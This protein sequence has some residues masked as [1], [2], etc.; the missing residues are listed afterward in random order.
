MK[1][2]FILNILFIL[3]G[4][5]G[6][7]EGYMMISSVPQISYQTEAKL[8]R[9]M[10]ILTQNQ[11]L[12]I[13]ESIRF[14]KIQNHKLLINQD[15]LTFDKGTIQGSTY[16]LPQDEAYWQKHLIGAINNSKGSDFSSVSSKIKELFKTEWENL[17]KQ[18]SWNSLSDVQKCCHVLVNTLEINQNELFF[19]N[20]N[21]LNRLSKSIIKIIDK[22]Q[23]ELVSQKQADTQSQFGWQDWLTPIGLI[24]VSI[25]GLIFTNQRQKTVIEKEAQSSDS[26]DNEV[27]KVAVKDPNI[28]AGDANSH[29]E[30]LLEYFKNFQE[31]YGNFYT[32]IEQLA[33]FPTDENTKRKIKSQLIE[34]GLH[35]HSFS[36]AYLFNYLHRPEK[37]P[38]VLLIQNKKKVKDLDP[39]LYKILTFNAYETNKRYRFLAKILIEMNIGSLDGALMFDTFL[40]EKPE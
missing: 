5:L 19:L 38:N 12:I 9:P 37:E 27:A 3:V 8:D 22:P 17:S 4:M 20:K 39:K 18:K 6:F 16:D 10:Y 11:G 35:A 7:R 31:L 24:L 29:E 13:F 33:E 32:N 26:N 34:M 21:G 23:L 14:I 36:R 1:N 28:E 25:L 40:P 15:T 30:L 2:R